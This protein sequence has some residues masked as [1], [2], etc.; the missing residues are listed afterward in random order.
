MTPSPPPS[1][2]LTWNAGLTVLPLTQSLPPLLDR[3]LVDTEIRDRDDGD[4]DKCESPDTK[5]M[6]KMELLP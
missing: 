5:G 4:E 6:G 3:H 1:V 2:P